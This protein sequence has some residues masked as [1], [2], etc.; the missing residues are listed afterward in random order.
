MWTFANQEGFGVLV[1]ELTGGAIANVNPASYLVQVW[2][3]FINFILFGSTAIFGIRPPWEI[4]WLAAP[5][6]PI[7]LAFWL[8]VIFYS[9]RIGRRYPN[10]K[11]ELR[12]LGAVILTL[13]IVYIFSPFGGDP[14]GRYFIPISIT[15]TLLSAGMIQ[16][17]ARKFSKW[18]YGLIVLV[19]VYNLW[20]TLASAGRFPPG[21]TTQFDHV[22]QVDHSYMD[23]LISFLEI[24][25]ETRGYTNYWVTY[26]LAFLSDEELIFIPRLPYHEDF[27][28]T[29]R[30]DRYPPY[31]DWVEDSNRIAYIT[32]N[33]PD[34]NEKLRDR[35][36][37]HGI[38][39]KEVLI[40]DYQVFYDLTEKISPSE[41]GIIED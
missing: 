7:I 37:Q 15:L 12:L 29:S 18:A 38:D 14:S 10:Q 27:R 34:L 19:M 28:Y 40:G 24:Q 36:L 4:R 22:A 26:P 1:H 9:I 39:W 11:E 8:G 25:G 23:E 2:M 21:L 16:D 30:D 33:H 31:R 13:A 20:G 6:L 32:T 5:L 17:L 41:L 3:H 35:F